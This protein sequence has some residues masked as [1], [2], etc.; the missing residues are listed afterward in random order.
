MNI[1]LYERTLLFRFVPGLEVV[2]SRFL[3]PSH[4]DAGVNVLHARD[5]PVSAVPGEEERGRGGAALPQGSRRP[6]R[7][8]VRQN[9][10]SL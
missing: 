5:P 7:V 4:P 6:N 9:R 3:H 10:R 8:G 2:S 1:H